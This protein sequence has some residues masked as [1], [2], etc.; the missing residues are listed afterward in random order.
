VASSR[1]PKPSSYGQFFSA[2]SWPHFRTGSFQAAS[3]SLGALMQEHAPLLALCERIFET[4][5]LSPN[6]RISL[7]ITLQKV[8]PD[9]WDVQIDPA[10]GSARVNRRRR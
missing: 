7:A 1:N 2:R 9:V 6:E 10:A 5:T 8:A 4:A 3:W